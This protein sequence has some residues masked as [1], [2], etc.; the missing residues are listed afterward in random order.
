MAPDTA[1]K[2]ILV[3]DDDPHIREILIQRLRSRGW[4]VEGAEN[5]DVAIGKFA[6]TDYDLL[7]LDLMMGSVGGNEVF[8]ALQSLPKK[9][10]VIIVSALAELWKRAH[11]ERDAYAVF[12]K[13]VEFNKLA[14]TIERALR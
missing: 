13:P 12:G 14:D 1:Q 8:L 11:N 10:R 6:M 4:A 3:V 9:P 5:G 7:I 2:R